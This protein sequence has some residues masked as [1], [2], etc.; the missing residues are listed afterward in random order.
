MENNE[1]AKRKFK[2]NLV[3][4]IV[5]VVAIAAVVAVA[6]WKIPLNNISNPN[7]K[8]FTFVVQ[9]SMTKDA[10][11]NVKIG[12][13]VYESNKKLELGK[14]T[15]VAVA[16]ETS[17]FFDYE[18]SQAVTSELELTEYVVITVEAKCS[19]T[20]SAIKTMSDYVVLAGNRID[21]R[22]SNFAGSGHIFHVY[23]DGE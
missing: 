15:D 16:P 1:T 20:D 6:L 21:M 2:I 22:G 14:I 7:S 5:F 3:D 11:K 12:D 17:I 9:L 18:T 23:R 4:I 13:T 19:E 10:Y 8:D